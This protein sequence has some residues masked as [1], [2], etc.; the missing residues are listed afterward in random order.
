[1]SKEITFIHAADI[2]LGSYIHSTN[3][4]AELNKICAEATF[5]AFRNVCDVAIEY[6]VDFLLLAGDLYDQEAK[7]VEANRFFNEQCARL[8]KK[9]IEV[10]LIAGNHDPLRELDLFQLPE[11][12]FLFGGDC[13]EIQEVVDQQGNLL[14]RIIGQSYRKRSE[15]RKMYST[16]TPPDKTVWNIGLLHTQLAGQNNNYVPCSVTELCAQ[17]GID[18]WALGHIHQCRLIRSRDPV[19]AY[20]GI[21]QGRDFGEVGVGGCLLVR[22]GEKG[23]VSDINISF[24]PTSPIILKRIEV[25]IDGEKD[26]EPGNL[27]DLEDLITTRTKQLLQEDLIVS[28]SLPAAEVREDL[29]SGF[30]VQW[31]LTGRGTI[32]QLL[33]EQTEEVEAILTENLRQRLSTFRPFVWTDSVI[34]RTGNPL[35]D[36]ESLQER[37]I[38][39][40]IKGIIDRIINDQVVQEEFINSIGQIWEWQTDHEN[41]DEDKLQLN[42][43]IL[44]E[45][46]QQAED[47]IIEDL[48]VGGDNYED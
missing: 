19:I 17:E 30:I 25:S 28:G 5:E 22:L 38:F 23:Y 4:S 44:R 27:A 9:G 43:E 18:Y 7:S 29:C 14:A 15:S 40:E 10:Y 39:R 42:E 35:P 33:R 24:I 1:M 8:Q 34:I 37:E 21:P 13:S 20:P 26:W 11:N 48:L 16:F 36:L 45:I 41:I 12:V 6:Q 2:H 47:M 46:L 32:N 31:V 3:L